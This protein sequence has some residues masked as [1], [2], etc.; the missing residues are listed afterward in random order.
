MSACLDATVHG[1]PTNRSRRPQ[2]GR[3][4]A[5]EHADPAS[6][7]CRS[8]PIHKKDCKDARVQARAL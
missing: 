6:P 3:G 5:C 8:V 4:R 1:V 2:E 7:A